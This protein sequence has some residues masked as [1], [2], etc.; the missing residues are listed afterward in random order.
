[1][2][3]KGSGSQSDHSLFAAAFGDAG[4]SHCRATAGILGA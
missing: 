2:M 3:W 1:M 4:T